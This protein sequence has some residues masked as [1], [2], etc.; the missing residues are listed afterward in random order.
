[1]VGGIDSVEHQ[2]IPNS[3]DLLGGSFRE[4]L[5]HHPNGTVGI[6]LLD[7]IPEHLSL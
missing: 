6:D 4:K 5:L 7:P 2:R 3:E 1:M